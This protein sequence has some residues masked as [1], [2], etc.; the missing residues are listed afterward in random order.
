MASYAKL[1]RSIAYWFPIIRRTQSQASVEKTSL[2]HKVPP[3][4]LI[5]RP[6]T[7]SQLQCL[8]L[9]PGGDFGLFD[10]FDRNRDRTVTEDNWLWYFKNTYH[11]LENDHQGSGSRWMGL[12]LQSLR[13][14]LRD[15]ER[16]TRIRATLLE[17]ALGLFRAM[18]AKQR[19]LYSLGDQ[20]TSGTVT[21]AS[22]YN[23]C[24]DTGKEW[25]EHLECD[26]RGQVWIRQWMKFVKG[27]YAKAVRAGGSTDKASTIQTLCKAYVSLCL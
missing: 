20:D 18:V 14:G 26:Q 12:L 4:T 13:E 10:M 11:K 27:A 16:V 25:L 17:G 2:Q 24:D 7:I 5:Q 8:Y 15:L 22:L 1:Q 23:R 3:V 21:K 6:T 9:I 19:G